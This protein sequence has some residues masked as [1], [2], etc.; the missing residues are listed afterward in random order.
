[1]VGIRIA[2]YPEVVRLIGADGF[3]IGNHTYDHPRLVALKP[4]EIANEL[5]FCA[6][7]LRAITGRQPY[8][9]RP[10]GVQYNDKVLATAHALGYVTVSWTCGAKDYD[11]QPAQYIADRIVDRTESGSIILLHQDNPTTVAALPSIVAR[12]RAEGYRF[13][14]VSQM[15]E[16]LGVKLPPHATTE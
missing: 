9:F 4:H 3:E 10:P 11:T 1:M 6:R 15:L 16:G 8:L 2:Q 12:L 5:R 7:R 14:T 13:V